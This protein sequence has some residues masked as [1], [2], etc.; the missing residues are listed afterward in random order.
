MSLQAGKRS[1]PAIVAKTRGRP[2]GS[3]V[4]GGDEHSELAL[5][6]AA[7]PR[8]PYC[9]HSEQTK[10][11]APLEAESRVG[12]YGPLAFCSILT[13]VHVT[14]TVTITEHEQR[15]QLWLA[16]TAHEHSKAPND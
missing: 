2:A 13:L 16:F 3:R 8:N 9:P 7:R 1:F 4:A 11:L 15:V 10:P 12:G 6:A 14:C 5:D